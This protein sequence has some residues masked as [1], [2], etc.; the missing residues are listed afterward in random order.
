M[1]KN[2][3]VESINKDIEGFWI[4]DEFGYLYNPI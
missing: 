4:I 2:S 3:F 1:E